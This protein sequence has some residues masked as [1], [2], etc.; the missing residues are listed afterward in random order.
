MEA[1]ERKVGDDGVRAGQGAHL[2]ILMLIQS[3]DEAQGR[4]ADNGSG[5]RK[6]ATKHSEALKGM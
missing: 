1:Q 4:Q 5:A 2:S 3:Q 6:S